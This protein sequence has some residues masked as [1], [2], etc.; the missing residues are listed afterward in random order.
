MT[1][2]STS[3]SW[4]LTP[5]WAAVGLLLVAFALRSYALTEL[6]PGLTHDEIAHLDVANQIRQGDWRLLYPRDYGIELGHQPLLAAAL[7]IWGNNLLAMRLP[8]LFIGMVGL[9]GLYAFAARL[10]RRRVGL[11]A[12]GAATVV[13]WSILMSRVILR[14]V[15]ELPLYA[16]ALYGLWR[17]FQHMSSHPRTGWRCFVLGG[18]ALGVD[19]YVHTIPRGLFMVAVLFGGYLGL[20]HAPLLRR[21]WRG[22]LLFIIVAEAAAA[23]MLFTAARSPEIDRLPLAGL[24]AASLLERLPETAPKILG[25]FM[26]AGDDGWEF[27]IPS[28]PVFEP[29]GAA[30]FGL[31]VWLALARL[32][33]PQYAFALIVLGVSL[34]PSIVLDPN[35]PFTRTI[36][37]QT[38]AF[39]LVG[40]GLDAVLIGF[41]RFRPP[42]R[43]L[44]PLSV[45]GA[46]LV[47]NLVRVIDEMFITWPALNPTRAVYNAE[48]RDFGRYLAARPA[49]PP[50]APCTLWITFPWEPLYHRSV[51]Q[52]AAP[53]LIGRTDLALRWHDCR[54]A[55]VIPNGAQF[56]FAH[57]DLEPLSAH[58]GRFLADPWL[59]NAQP[60]PGVPGAMFVDARAALERQ[61]AAWHHL[62]VAWP[63]EAVISSAVQ[64]PV[65]FNHALEL[66]GYRI[67]PA[68]VTAGEHVA[69]ITYWRVT[70]AV[71]DDTLLFTHLYRTP[72]DV[73]AQQDQFD[74]DGASLQPGD[75]FIQQHEFITAPPDTPPG[76]YSIGVGAYHRDSGERWPIFAGDQRA[77][78]RLFLDQVQVLP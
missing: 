24:S 51:A 21:V 64:L 67:E 65:N 71:P 39:A 34:L 77:A 46:L 13:W 38:V 55:L 62:K 75:V 74:V 6:P 19:Q 12:L 18:L 78:D 8:S 33:Q 14:E 47:V 52:T 16:L 49:A 7:S 37:A 53:Y 26:F 28:R 36:S 15:L 11:L 4:K 2:D 69:V 3:A 58:L 22:L 66:I 9:A 70:G 35:F 27:N 68:H 5:L 20:F 59:A 31:G 45:I 10:L 41:A 25:E 17:G 30:L 1:D 48:L 63:P 23:P 72:T 57:S 73:L 56:I 42:L 44:G 50:I 76:A 29:L 43:T 54:Y 60:V 40:V 61:L 32:R